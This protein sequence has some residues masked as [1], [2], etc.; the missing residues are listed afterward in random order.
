MSGNN[1][2]P[3]AKPLSSEQ[4]QVDAAYEKLVSVIA[5]L[6]AAQKI[7]RRD[8]PNLTPRQRSEMSR[9]VR[10]LERQHTSLQEEMEILSL[11]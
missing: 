10:E 5:R 3:Q 6:K 1:L 7:L 8:W 11:L 2:Q 9:N 4:E